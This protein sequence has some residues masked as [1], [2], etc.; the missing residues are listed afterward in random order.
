MPLA[1]ASGIIRVNTGKYHH[2][3]TSVMTKTPVECIQCERMSYH[4]APGKPP[5]QLGKIERK[6][7]KNEE[8]RTFS[9][10]MY[11]KLWI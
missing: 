1:K 8:E 6:K 4:A 7:K 3:H 5:S 11:S 2:L 10:E 9:H